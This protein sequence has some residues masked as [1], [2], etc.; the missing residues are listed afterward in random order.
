MQTLKEVQE[1]LRLAYREL[2]SRQVKIHGGPLSKQVENWDDVQKALKGT[3][4]E[5]FL[6]SDYRM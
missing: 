2:T 6:H 1:F 4:Y 3:S 5:R